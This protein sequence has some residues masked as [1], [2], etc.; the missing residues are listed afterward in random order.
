MKEKA[1]LDQK[2]VAAVHT[3]EERCCN[4]KKILLCWQ[5]Y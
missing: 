1:A 4:P 3:T 2:K 5:I